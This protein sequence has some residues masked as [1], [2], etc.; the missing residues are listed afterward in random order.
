MD[1]HTDKDYWDQSRGQNRRTGRRFRLF[2]LLTFLDMSWIKT[3]NQS[4]G[5]SP[6]GADHH[7]VPRLVPK[8]V[9]E[10]RRLA[11]VLPVTDDLE[12][13]TIQKNKTT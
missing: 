2:L 1:T 10:R 4:F 11:S 7:I 8:V 6:L 5:R 13:L 9:A 12:R 3:V